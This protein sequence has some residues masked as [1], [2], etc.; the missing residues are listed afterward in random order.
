MT[1]TTATAS[2]S[3]TVSAIGTF[4]QNSII[5][6]PSVT[7]LPVPVSIYAVPQV[8]NVVYPYQSRGG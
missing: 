1:D 4:T 7:D 5:L 3:A 8:V 6:N 2:G